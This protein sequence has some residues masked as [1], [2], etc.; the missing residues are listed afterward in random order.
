M[1]FSLVLYSISFIASQRIVPPFHVEI[2]PLLCWLPWSTIPHEEQDSSPEY[3]G[4]FPLSKVG[5]IAC[6]MQITPPAL[7]RPLVP[8]LGYYTKVHFS[9]S[10]PGLVWFYSGLNYINSDE[11]L[12]SKPAIRLSACEVTSSR[13]L[14]SSIYIAYKALAT[15]V[16]GRSKTV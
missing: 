14:G 15:S 4:S 12:T 11:N 9:F 2:R 7:R 5:F 3:T 6:P 16:N 8:V 1:F 10:Y 13:V